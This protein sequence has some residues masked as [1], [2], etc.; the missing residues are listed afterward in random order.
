MAV[1]WSDPCA[2]AEALRKAYYALVS[3]EL[4]QRVRVR[5]GD[6]EEDVTFNAA[7]VELLRS[8]L[9][10]AEA[11]CAAKNGTVGRRFAIRAG[12]RRA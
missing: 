12:H 6:G 10:S 9:R 8:E 11:E 1:D 7:N 3:G 4:E 2:R 5:G